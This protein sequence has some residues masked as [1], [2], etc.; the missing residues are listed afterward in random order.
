MMAGIKAPVLHQY[1]LHLTGLLAQLEG[2]S[3][4]GVISFVIL[5]VVIHRDHVLFSLLKGVSHGGESGSE[6]LQST[7]EV[8][9]LPLEAVQ[10]VRRARDAVGDQ[11]FD[12][13]LD[14]VAVLEGV[15]HS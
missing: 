10:S 14:A 9:V 13:L 15:D 12:E 11:A 2:V 8:F 6:M 5:S 4:S 7:F 3:Q 1:L